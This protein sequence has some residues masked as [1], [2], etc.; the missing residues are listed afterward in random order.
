MTL[1]IRSASGNARSMWR[2][3]LVRAGRLRLCVQMKMHSH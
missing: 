2:L 3:V 1:T